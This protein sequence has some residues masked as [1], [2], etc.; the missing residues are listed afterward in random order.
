MYVVRA[1]Y[2]FSSSRRHT[3]P[4]NVW[5]KVRWKKGRP[6]IDKS[7]ISLK[8]GVLRM[9]A[10]HTHGELARV[11]HGTTPDD[12]SLKL[13]SQLDTCMIYI[14]FSKNVTTYAHMHVGVV[15]LL[16]VKVVYVY[17]LHPG[18]ASN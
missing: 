15:S 1:A 11:L 5:S 4:M 13:I 3:V 12:H 9:R 18:N 17:D 16:Q 10:A 6:D 8:D 14:A 7:W 2:D